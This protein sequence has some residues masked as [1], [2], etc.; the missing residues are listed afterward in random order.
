M[1]FGGRR[2][3]FDGFSKADNRFIRA[4]EFGLHHAERAKS[5]S[6]IGIAFQCSAKLRLGL[7]KLSVASHGEAKIDESARVRGIIKR[8]LLEKRR[9][10]VI[11]ALL[12]VQDAEIVQ[13]F[14]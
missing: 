12:R 14:R 6:V 10:V 7:G 1:R 4:A 8:G 5:A 13:S 11:L 3:E 2:L 9:G